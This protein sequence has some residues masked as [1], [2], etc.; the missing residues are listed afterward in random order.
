MADVQ[1]IVR[2]ADTDIDGTKRIVDA[3]QD[4]KGIGDTVANAVE[5]NLEFDPE[6]R[7]G[8]LEEDELERIEEVIKDP[9]EAGIPRWARNRR[10]DRETGEN[11][12]VIG[13][14]LDLVKEFDIRR[15][16]ETG[17][18]RGKRHEMGLPVRGQ[19]TQGSFRGGEK[20]GVERERVQEE[21]EETTEE[22]E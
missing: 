11:K 7:I 1:E 20:I 3:I 16:K 15:Y 13:A 2:V 4:I 22:E 19:Q 14:D 18:Y 10:K 12:H 8:S 5:G 9:E 17:T 6:T 21:A